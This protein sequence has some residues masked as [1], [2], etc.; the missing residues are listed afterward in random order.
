ML[1][2]RRKAPGPCPQVFILFFCKGLTFLWSVLRN[3]LS[4][5]VW[6]N[7]WAPLSSLLNQLP[8]QPDHIFISKSCTFLRHL[9]IIPS[10][11]ILETASL[12]ALL[13]LLVCPCPLCLQHTRHTHPQLMIVV[14]VKP[15]CFWLEHH[16][17]CQPHLFTV[18]AL[19]DSPPHRSQNHS[20]K[21]HGFD[22][23]NATYLI[24]N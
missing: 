10:R 22:I 23:I 12:P 18:A 5:R 24:L 4:G 7:V 1:V 8:L 19:P 20:L 14:P 15:R 21:K 6:G 9:N 3:V 16:N 17:H 2:A 11:S 13:S